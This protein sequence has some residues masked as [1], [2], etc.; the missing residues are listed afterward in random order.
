[1][2]FTSVLLWCNLLNFSPALAGKNSIFKSIDSQIFLDLSADTLTKHRDIFTQKYN[3][4]QIYFD[5]VTDVNQ[6]Q[7]VSPQNWAYEAL[8][9]LVEKYGCIGASRRRDI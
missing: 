6:L 3:Q 5:R 2:P 7:D 8:R 9:S 1:M 4:G